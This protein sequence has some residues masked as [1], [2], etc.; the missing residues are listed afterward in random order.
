[1]QITNA[2]LQQ[3]HT[4]CTATITRLLCLSSEAELVHLLSFRFSALNL[5]LDQEVLQTV[6]VSTFYMLN[7]YGLF[8]IHILVLD[9]TTN[10]ELAYATACITSVQCALQSALKEALNEAC[11]VIP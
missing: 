3:F 9:I 10:M 8:Y 5:F 2:Q 6:T 1:M 11:K 7:Y 4:W